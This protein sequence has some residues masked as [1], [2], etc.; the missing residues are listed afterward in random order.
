MEY[1]EPQ[2]YT[3]EQGIDAAFNP[4]PH[5]DNTN[6]SLYSIAEKRGWNSYQFDIVKRIDRALK[7][8][9]F[10]EDLDKTID[11]INLWKKE[12]SQ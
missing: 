8:G 3:D 5:Y 1:K 4:Q 12:N 11:L 6:G 2:Y 10:E 9:K 7:K